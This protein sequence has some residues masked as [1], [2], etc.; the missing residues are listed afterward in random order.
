MCILND[1]KL[2]FRELGGGPED[3]L[4]PR[5]AF[6][7]V[8]REGASHLQE[9]QRLVERLQDE[10]RVRKVIASGSEEAFATAVEEC[11]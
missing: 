4:Y 11:L 8:M 6:M 5:L 7:L 3:I 10:D 1:R 9:L 2:T